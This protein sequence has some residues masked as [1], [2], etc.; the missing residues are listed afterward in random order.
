[1]S[2]HAYIRIYASCQIQSAPCFPA[3][4]E[5]GKERTTNIALLKLILKLRL[6]VVNS[7]FELFTAY[8]ASNI[9]WND[10]YL[11]Y[12]LHNMR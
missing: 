2:L 9:L 4:R 6:I 10:N 3:S 11:L 1:M 8:Y 12:L 7:A 5:A